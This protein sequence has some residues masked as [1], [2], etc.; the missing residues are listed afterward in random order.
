[1]KTIA[2]RF[3]VLLGGLALWGLPALPLPAEAPPA[4]LERQQRI[5]QVMT[6]VSPAV[7]AIV[8]DPDSENRNPNEMGSG[9]GVIV[10]EDGLILTAAHVL[11]AVGEEFNVI[12]ST[13]TRVKAK[14]LGKNR[15]RD[16]ALAKITEPGKYPHVDRAVADS[17]TEGEWCVA[18]GHPGGYEVDRAAPLRLGR[19]LE[20]DVDGFIVSDCTLSGGDSGGPL[21][22]LDGKLIG[23]HSSIG[24]RV[25]ENRHVPMAAFEKDWDRLMDGE[26]WGRLGMV[27]RAP[28]AEGRRNTEPEPAQGPAPDQA[29]LGV[30][31]GSS[32]LGQPGAI[33]NEVTPR[34][35]AGKAGV[36]T[37]DI[38]TK[39]NGKAIPD[40]EA[41]GVNV[42]SFKPGDEIILTV[43]RNG[44]TL[45][46]K[47]KLIAAK[48]LGNE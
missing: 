32:L 12:L 11:Q 36:E 9:S 7:V 25:A 44:K 24:W 13:G 43:E 31:V 34:S 35:P 33:V 22:N 47:T 41:L 20:K 26:T 38:I 16:S 46:L 4:L 5:Q 2:S 1:M 6:A 19:I 3:F 17:L 39:I 10:T 21:F 48:E 23:I 30:T 14:A 37:G 40:S 18:L 8:T 28:R 42:R 27:E 29:L 15:S 45:E